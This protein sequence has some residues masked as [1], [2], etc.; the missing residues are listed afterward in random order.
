MLVA[1]RAGSPP[2]EVVC[3]PIGATLV[4]SQSTRRP[5]NPPQRKTPE[6]RAIPADGAKRSKVGR[7]CPMGSPSQV[8]PGIRRAFPKIEGMSGG[9]QGPHWSD[10]GMVSARAGK[11]TPDRPQPIGGSLPALQDRQGRGRAQG[12]TIYVD[13]LRSP[14]G[15]SERMALRGHALTGSSADGLLTSRPRRRPRSPRP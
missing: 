2:L 11:R 8:E 4:Q 15:A 3:N 6:A 7:A 10:V 1:I 5:T 12:P 13:R 9:G 14:P